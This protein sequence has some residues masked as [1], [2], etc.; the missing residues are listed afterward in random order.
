M[1]IF[2]VNLM[3]RIERSLDNLEFS[4]EVVIILQKIISSKT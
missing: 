1:L 2:F 3:V 4:R